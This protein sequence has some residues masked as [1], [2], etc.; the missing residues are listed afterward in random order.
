MLFAALLLVHQTRH[1]AALDV[2]ARLSDDATKLFSSFRVL[3]LAKS[4][5]LVY[6]G[7]YTHSTVIIFVH[8]ILNMLC[9]MDICIAPLA[10][11]Y[12]EALSARQA[13]EKKSL[14]TT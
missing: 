13:G 2:V 4:S 9:N 1:Q 8:G 5:F 11:G 12:S 10:E 7:V 3:M 6:S 14:Q